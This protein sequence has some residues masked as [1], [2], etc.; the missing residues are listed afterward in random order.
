MYDITIIGA[1]IVGLAT[2]YQ[3]SER[4]PDLK[5]CVIEKEKQ[6]APHQTSHNSGVI[7]SGIYYKPGGTKA[8]NC[9]KGYRYLLEFCDKHDIPYNLCGKVIVATKEAE[10]P[11]LEDIFQRGLANGMQNTRKISRAETLALEPHVRAVEAIYVPQAGIIDYKQVAEKY[12]ALTEAKGGVAAL[13]QAVHDIQV[14]NE[15]V[16]VRTSQQEVRTKV[17]VTCAGLFSDRVAKMTGQSINFQVLPFRGEYYLLR[18]EKKY[19]VNNL[20]YPVP[21][22]AFPFLGVHSTPRMDGR[23]ELGPNAV[24]AFQR[25]G[26]NRWQVDFSELWET[27]SYP[28]FRQIASK[29]WKT[30][31]G[32]LRR[33]FSKAAFVKALQQLLPEVKS[34]DLLPGG[35]GV[36]AQACDPQGNLL[37]DFLIL[38]QP[39]VVNVCNAPSPAATSSLAIGEMVAEKA[40]HHLAIR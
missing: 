28:G 34:E 37:D 3:L 31:L 22:P 39:R 32:E 36:R 35:S 6:L 23:I 13:G 14:R 27:I 11:L 26:Y 24:L 8:L 18:E 21:N 2:A 40:L 1:G 16:V 30:G 20:I 25:E 9:R 5:I 17:L 4:Q 15:E 29:Y 38:E 12:W 10:R 33:S 7:H 19:L